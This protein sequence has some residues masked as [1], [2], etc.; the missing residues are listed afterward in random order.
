MVL[1]VPE[2][3]WLFF[4]RPAFLERV[5]GQRLDPERSVLARFKPKRVLSEILEDESPA[6]YERLIDDLNADDLKVLR[7][8]APIKELIEFVT[9][10]SPESRLQIT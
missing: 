1:T 5:T 4:A 10:H 2:I 9:E 3:E 6:A 8:T 7:E